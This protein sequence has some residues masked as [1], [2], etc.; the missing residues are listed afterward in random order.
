MSLRMLSLIP[1]LAAAASAAID[2][3]HFK[4]V[5]SDRLSP[6][7]LLFASFFFAGRAAWM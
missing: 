6:Q 7:L 2:S 5:P 1:S 3:D 4:V